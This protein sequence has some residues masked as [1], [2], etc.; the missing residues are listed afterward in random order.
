MPPT[1][2]SWIAVALASPS[3]VHAV[4]ARRPSTVRL[5]VGHSAGVSGSPGRD[6]PM[7]QELEYG[8]WMVGPK[9]WVT[10]LLI[11]TSPAS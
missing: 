11:L 6:A 10:T 4:R 8:S 5:I 7:L 2:S 9:I 1:G 3:V